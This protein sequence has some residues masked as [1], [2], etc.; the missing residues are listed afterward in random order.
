MKPNRMKRKFQIRKTGGELNLGLPSLVQSKPN[1]PVTE[2]Q[3]VV[4]ITTLMNLSSER[5]LKRSL[6]PN[7]TKVS[8]KENRR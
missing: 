2:R 1:V 8:D 6:K 7:E 3:M 4:L 5:F